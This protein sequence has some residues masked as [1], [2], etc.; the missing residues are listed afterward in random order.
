MD[1]YAVPGWLNRWASAQVARLRRCW[2]WVCIL[3]PTW[4][5]ISSSMYTQ[6]CAAELFALRLSAFLI[7]RLLVHS[8]SSDTGS[9]LLSS[10]H[11][12]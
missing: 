1:A 4:A 12:S 8:M 3:A 2:E 11:M 7:L 10:E 9:C 6:R 5:V